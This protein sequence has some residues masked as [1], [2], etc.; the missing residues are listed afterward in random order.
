MNSLLPRTLLVAGLAFTLTAC[1]RSENET[2][3]QNTRETSQDAQAA[4]NRA[5]DN[6]R[7][8]MNRAAD[9]TRDAM[10]RAGNAIE[11]SWNGFK[12]ATFERKNDFTQ[13]AQ[14]MKSRT[15]AEI[16]EIKAEASSANASASRKAAWEQI[17]SDQ[18]NFDQKMN[19]L[20]R[21]SKD[22]WQQAKQETIA[23]WEKL[24]A[25]IRKARA[26]ID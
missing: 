8:A 3:R 7:D 14:S 20:G 19:A 5:A 25:S 1:T 23:A 11:N 21:A 13:H 24:E 9:N 15:E 2:V 17:K 10:N 18:A 26:D 22:T 12:D 6:T 16:A 4:A